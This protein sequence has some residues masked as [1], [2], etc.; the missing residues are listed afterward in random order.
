[1]EERKTIITKVIKL[2]ALGI[3]ERKLG[4]TGAAIT[5]ETKVQDLISKYSITKIELSLEPKTTSTNQN[6]RTYTQYTNPYAR[7]FNNNDSLEDILAQL[8]KMHDDLKREEKNQRERAW[9]DEQ[10]RKKPEPEKVFRYKTEF[11]CKKDPSERLQRMC[12][13]CSVELE[14]F[15]AHVQKVS[16]FGSTKYNV[17][18]SVIG[19]L[20]NLTNF[21][22]YFQKNI[23]SFE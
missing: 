19:K 3:S 17:I 7:E 1:M 20:P 5:I 15:N 16:W 14:D 9:R 6:Q 23:D 12:D 10:E 2:Q 4:N 18:F 22:Q 11:E 8:K 13:Y 21:K